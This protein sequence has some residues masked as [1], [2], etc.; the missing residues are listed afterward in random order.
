M[1]WDSALSSFS[2]WVGIT[3]FNEW[4]EGSEIEPSI[5]FGNQYIDL[6]RQYSR[7]FKGETA[8]GWVMR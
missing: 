7:R 6:T 3:S 1:M 8:V 4:H 5:E 2:E